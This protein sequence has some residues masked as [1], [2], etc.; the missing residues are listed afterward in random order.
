NSAA[1]M[2][3]RTGSDSSSISQAGTSATTVPAISGARG[4]RPAPKPVASHCTGSRRDGRT[5]T[6]LIDTAARSSPLS[7]AV[8]IARLRIDPLA[9]EP[10]VDPSPVGHAADA[11]ERR[12]AAREHV[13]D[14]P[15]RF[16]RRREAELVVVAAGKREPQRSL[17]LEQ[18]LERRRQRQRRDLDERAAAARG[19]DV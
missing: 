6:P 7:L 2:P 17:R 8:E 14:P 10:P 12:P 5:R 16:R 1:T 3:I 19:A 18:R 9:V 15:A 11:A 4:A 13:L